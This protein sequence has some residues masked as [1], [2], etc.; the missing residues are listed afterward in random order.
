MTYFNPN[1]LIVLSFL[2]SLVITTFVVPKVLLISFKNKLFD[3]P[4]ERKVHHRITPRLGGVPFFLV[5]L[6]SVGL[7]IACAHIVNTNTLLIDSTLS[8]QLLLSMCALTLLYFVGIAD[9]LIGVGY[10]SKFIAQIFCGVILVCSGLWV[11]NLYGILGVYAIP[12]W[13]GMPLTVFF[14]VFIINAINLIDGID[15]LASGLS[16]ITL[17]FFGLLL[18]YMDEWV[19]AILAFASL[20]ALL[21]FFY[22]NVFGTRRRKHKIFMGDTGSLTIGMIISILTIKMI[23]Y[24]PLAPV[25]VSNSIVVVFSSLI[26]PLFDVIRVVFLRMR[27]GKPLFKPDKN[28]IHHKFLALGF[29]HRV[30]MLS[31]LLMALLFA[32]SNLLLSDYLNINIL[33]ACDVVIWT[34]IHILLSRKISKRNLI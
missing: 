7:T 28:H 17:L 2:V 15:G 6:F 34:L 1:Y 16:S 9:D 19:Y 30:A 24:D 11:N 20:G 29:S 25:Q 23:M 27:S 12:A 21:S 5:I 32:I 14:V 8:L 31:I 33:L 4:N 13:F 10:R 26:V 18:I 3:I 22:Y